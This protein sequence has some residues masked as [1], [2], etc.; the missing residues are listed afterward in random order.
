VRDEDTIFIA[1]HS[2][3]IQTITWRQMQTM[4][5]ARGV[6]VVQEQETQ[7]VKEFK[8]IDEGKRASKQT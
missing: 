4:R 3:K 2:L 6:A 5:E 8:T 1:S 7:V